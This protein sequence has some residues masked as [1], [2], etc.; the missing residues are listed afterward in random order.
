VD[1]ALE[2]ESGS[3]VGVE[4][5]FTEWLTPKRR[6]AAPFKE[7]YFEIGSQLWAAQGLPRCQA[8]AGDLTHGSEQ[9]RFL[10]AA[11]LLKHALGLATQ[12]GD[13]FALHYLYYDVACATSE[14]HREEVERFADRVGSELRLRADTYQQMYG[15]L[16]SR[17]DVD[18]QYIGYLGRRYFPELA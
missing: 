9:F 13:Q 7:K 12:R 16:A 15:N 14:V 3:V 4:S 2:L 11:Q 10:N 6:N 18:S 8:L 5:K 17:G 1:V